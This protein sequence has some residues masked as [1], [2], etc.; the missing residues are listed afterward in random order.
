MRQW[1]F[2]LIL[3]CMTAPLV[4]AG[5]S[6]LALLFPERP[7]YVP[8]GVGVELAK[9]SALEGWITNEQTGVRERRRVDAQGGWLLIRP[10]QQWE[11]TESK[12]APAPQS[13]E[14]ELDE[15][16]RKLARGGR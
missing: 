8:P 14:P 12:P 15:T 6:P 13:V 3:F 2:V 4:C 16:P 9:D 1:S 10:R 7:V 11:A 5:C